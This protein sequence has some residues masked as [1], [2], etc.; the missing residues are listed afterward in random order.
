MSRLEFALQQIKT[1]RDYTLRILADVDPADWFRQPAEGVT[2]IAWQI[3][4]LAI[5]E[6]RLALAQLRGTRTED[7]EF[8]PGNYVELFGRG[9]VPSPDASK[10]PTAES[11]RQTFD[12]IHQHALAEL[13]SLPDGDLDSPPMR[14]HPL[15]NT[16]I[17]SLLWCAR[18]ELIHAG[19]IGLL[20][21]LLGQ[22]ATW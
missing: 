10:Y 19:Q 15:F 7:E 11:I 14:E 13:P 3:G 9:S 8:V 18:H 22:P 4:H 12:S 17:E 20:K 1:S 21:R 5:A 16:K 6:Y 2:H